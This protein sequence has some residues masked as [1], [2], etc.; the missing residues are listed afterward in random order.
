MRRFLIFCMLSFLGLNVFAQIRLK[1]EVINEAKQ[2]IEKYPDQKFVANS[3]DE[4]YKFRYSSIDKQV[5]A[6]QYYSEQ[7]MSLKE[8]TYFR[9]NVFYDDESEVSDIQAKNYRNSKKL[10]FPSFDKYA[11][12]GVF[13]QDAMLCHFG[14][15][16]STRGDNVK[17]SYKKEYEDI[18][19]FTKVYFHKPYPIKKETKTFII[20]DWLDMELMEVNFDG[21]DI[22][23]TEV[24]NEKKKFRTI[25][26]IFNDI[27]PIVSGNYSASYSNQWPHILVLSKSY[28]NYKTKYNLF[29]S[30]E[31]LY[32]WY[33]GLTKQMDNKP[34]DFKSIVDN[35][36]KDK[37]TDKE[38]IEAIYYWVQDNI[39]YIA[40][41]DGIMGFKPAD[42]NEVCKKRFGDCKGMANLT[43][44]MLK[45]A[46]YDARLTWIGTRS[47]PYNYSTPSLAVDNHMIA[48]VILDGKRFFLD[49]TEKG[50][51]FNDYAY[52]I[53]GQDVLIENGNDFII[54]TVPSFD[55]NHNK[56]I[57][58]VS[59]KIEGDKLIG[60]GSNQYIGE[61]RIRMYRSLFSV[62]KADLEKRICKYLGNYSKNYLI[63]N[64][65]TSDYL[66]RDLPISFSYDISISN[67]ITS[68]SNEKYINLEMDF[69][70]ANLKTEEH[71][72]TDLDFYKKN[73]IERS[74][75]L[76]IPEGIYKVDYLPENIDIDTDE[77]RFSLT[78]N[79][80]S[81][82]SII[83]YKKQIIIKK[84]QVSV[85]NFEA[86]NK[87]IKKINKCY[88]NQ[89]VLIKK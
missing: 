20:P 54:D 76:E 80:N 25:T 21:F 77:Y 22:Q 33:L 78:F 81:E 40:Y 71:R 37:T 4:E 6:Y 70:Y 35:L 23:K 15:S 49:A 73:D 58:N 52:R 38:K 9:V 84:G 69:D 5:H 68:V 85:S 51:A 14:F 64:L 26:Y 1:P 24:Y 27:D 31:D 88:N 46:G 50:V 19:Y 43:V 65:V 12:D 39:R 62:S 82:K 11:T 7:I 86:W 74:I 60:K 75:T 30:T 72:N 89:I 45:L 18:K 83:E 36:V 79:Y 57:S 42:A 56:E 10:L 2:Y 28:T 53:Q 67:K 34:E 16:L 87:A 3:I 13:Y 8:N 59:L 48:T 44:E 61:E 63:S 47:L 29:E 41:E 66:N 32:K 55:Y 17:Y